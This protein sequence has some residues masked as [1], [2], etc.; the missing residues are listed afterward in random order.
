M[1]ISS[2]PL[3]YPGGK[4]KLY[5]LIKPIISSNIK[6]TIYI[7]P[8]AGGAGLALTLLFNNDVEELVLNDIDY[9]IY[10][11]WDACLNQTDELCYMID[12]CTVNIETWNDQKNIYNNPICYSKLEVGFATFY[13]NRCNVSGVIQGGPIGGKEQK[14]KY[15]IDARFNKVDLIKRIR[16]IMAYRD[17]IQFY[18]MDASCFIQSEV[19]KYPQC[20]TFLNI[21]PPYVKKGP[22]LY[23]NSFTTYDHAT[24]ANVIQTIQHKWIVTYDECDLV[25]EL[26]E[27]YNKI[28][29]T[30]NYSAGQ[31]KSGNELLIFSDSISYPN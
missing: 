19:P 2:S 31:T 6:N 4:T 26:Y 10:S 15:L 22:L 30:L 9:C 24:L 23:H 21:D 8:F 28:Q 1:P 18:N 14:G 3:R 12:N 25:Y 17:R 16:R 7:E 5:N 27:N 29:I 20:R 11:F 13:L